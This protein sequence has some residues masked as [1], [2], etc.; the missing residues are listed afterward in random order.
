MQVGI[1]GGGG[2]EDAKNEHMWEG[3]DAKKMKSNTRI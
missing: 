3:E 1:C 2:G